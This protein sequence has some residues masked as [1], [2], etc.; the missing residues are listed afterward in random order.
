M[1]CIRRH[2]MLAA[3]ARRLRRDFVGWHFVDDEGADAWMNHHRREGHE[4][5]R[6]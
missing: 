4:Q 3:A 6:A 5:P 1:R 2:F